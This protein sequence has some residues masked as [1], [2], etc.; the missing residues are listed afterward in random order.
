M[1]EK[2][3]QI[4]RQSAVKIFSL[5]NQDVNAPTMLITW[6]TMLTVLTSQQPRATMW[7]ERRKTKQISLFFLSIAIIRLKEKHWRELYYMYEA[8]PAPP[9]TASHGF[10]S[11]RSQHTTHKI[12]QLKILNYLFL[13]SIFVLVNK[14]NIWMIVRRP[15]ETCWLLFCF[16]AFNSELVRSV[17]FFAS[18]IGLQPFRSS[19]FHSSL[20]LQWII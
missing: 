20:H 14:T 8:R 1:S 12:T 16:R 5:A 11:G 13:H 2:S 19:T 17:L 9:P 6:L 4:K 7:Y 10:Y 15:L 18:S 3:N